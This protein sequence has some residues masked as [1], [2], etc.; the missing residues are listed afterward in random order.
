MRFS[1]MVTKGNFDQLEAS[2]W[3]WKQILYNRVGTGSKDGHRM[4]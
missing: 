2:A 4:R 3:G 1:E